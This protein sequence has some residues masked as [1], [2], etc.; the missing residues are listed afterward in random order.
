M[1]PLVIA[2]SYRQMEAKERNNIIQSLYSPQMG[3]TLVA[4][5][6]CDSK[7]HIFLLAEDLRKLQETS[8]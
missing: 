8:P 4:D 5:S 3:N 6:I 7:L 1:I 2:F